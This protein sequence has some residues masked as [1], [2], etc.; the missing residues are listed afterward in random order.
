MILA[1]DN[2]H[3]FQHLAKLNARL[4]NIAQSP[5]DLS[6]WAADAGIVMMC[7][8]HAADV[9][10]PA[11]EWEAYNRWTDRILEEFFAQVRGWWLCAR[12]SLRCCGVVCNA[13]HARLRLGAPGRQGARSRSAHWA[14]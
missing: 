7:T 6:S 12:A 5:L 10:N 3:H 11:K 1:T 8:L 13:A 2:A 9:S 14:R 4:G